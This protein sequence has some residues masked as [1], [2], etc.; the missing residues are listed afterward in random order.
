MKAFILDSYGRGKPLRFGDMPMPEL[1]DHDVLVEIH[2]AGVNPIDTKIRSGEF[3]LV[4]PFKL[5][6][7]LGSDLAGIV[8]K[9]GAKVTAFK[10][11]DAVFGHPDSSV[12]GTFAEYIAVAEADLALKPQSLPM[13]EAA[14]VP[15][16]ALTAWQALFEQAS[17]KAGDKVFIQAGSGGVG[18]FAIQLAKQAGA[19]VATTAGAASA[20]LVRSLGADVVIDYRRHDFTKVL[21]GFDF[22]LNS[23]DAKTLEQSIGI[24]KPGGQVISISGPPD[25]AFAEAI[26][27]NWFVRQVMRLLSAKARRQAKRQGVHYSFLFMQASGAQLAKLAA[28]IDAGTVRTVVDRIY[29]FAETNDALAYVESGRAKGK[30]VIKIK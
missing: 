7:A 12:V 29:P 1:G 11:G 19:S 20:E 15:L 10:P 21:S 4:L 8:V 24:L 26:G 9:V 14:S 13:E 23:Q 30:V 16:V 22:V 6:M 28:M 27:A 18:V 2:A 17:V 3:K 25:P 5:P